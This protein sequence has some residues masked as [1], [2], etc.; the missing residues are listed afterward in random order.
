ML[1]GDQS[2]LVQVISNLISNAIK[3]TED[4][5]MITIDVEADFESKVFIIKI[6]DNGRGIDPEI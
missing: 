5:G 1:R 6:I 4:K 3:F 2:R